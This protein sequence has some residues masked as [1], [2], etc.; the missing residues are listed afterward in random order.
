MKHP[1]FEDP[2][3]LA[4]IRLPAE[5]GMVARILKTVAA[6]NPKCGAASTADEKWL[7]IFNPEPLPQPE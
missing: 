3:I 5:L 4:A 1:T 6:K 2:R 7:L